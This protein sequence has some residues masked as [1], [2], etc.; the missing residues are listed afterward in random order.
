M[1]FTTIPPLLEVLTMD[2]WWSVFPHFISRY[3]AVERWGMMLHQSSSKGPVNSEG[4]FLGT[5]SI[6]GT[7]KC[8]PAHRDYQMHWLGKC[9]Y[10]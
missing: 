9:K 6:K 3:V 2:W 7:D 4:L 8:P 1:A 10:T 5:C